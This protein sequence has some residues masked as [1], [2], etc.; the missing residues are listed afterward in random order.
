VEEL[1]GRAR[2]LK[3]PLEKKQESRRRAD[4]IIAQITQANVAPNERQ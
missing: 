3:R 4:T 2:F 1:R